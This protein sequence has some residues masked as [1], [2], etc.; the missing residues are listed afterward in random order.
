M[1]VIM[2]TMTKKQRESTSKYLY[3]ISK[4]IA[5]LAIVGD[6]VKEKHNILIIASGLIATVVFFVWAY[7]LEGEG[8]G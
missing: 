2:R 7:T 3:D 8:N 5:L 1:R 4:G 6:F